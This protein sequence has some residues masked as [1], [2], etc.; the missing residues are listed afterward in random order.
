MVS[1]HFYVEQLFLCFYF[2]IHT[3]LLNNC[4][5]MSGDSVRLLLLLLQFIRRLVAHRNFVAKNL[6]SCH[7]YYQGYPPSGVQE[8]NIFPLVLVPGS[9]MLFFFSILTETP[10]FLPESLFVLSNL[11]PALKDTVVTLRK[12]TDKTQCFPHLKTL[13]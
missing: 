2:I 10:R 6:T 11:Q 1:F 13:N 4:H 3:Q 12:H 7:E 5:R 8:E 9:S